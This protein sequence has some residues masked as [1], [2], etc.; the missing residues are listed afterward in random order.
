M[1]M[2]IK[3]TL[4]FFWIKIQKNLSLS[5]VTSKLLLAICL[6]LSVSCQRKHSLSLES[7]K[8]PTGWGYTI[9]H[10]NKIIIKQTVI[11]VIP[12]N[13]S[14]ENENDALKVG[15]LVLQKLKDNLPP[16]ITKKD[17]FLLSIKN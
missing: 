4:K 5:I 15:R 16:T 6:F 8:T 11:P 2:I 9:L 1:M 14:F 17:L 12:E 7:I 10:D 13:K 3:T